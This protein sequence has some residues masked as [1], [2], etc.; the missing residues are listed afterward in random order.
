MFLSSERIHNVRVHGPT[1][2]GILYPPSQHSGARLQSREVP[3]DHHTV[4]NQSN[5][6]VQVWDRC[7]PHTEVTLNIMWTSGIDSPKSAYETLNGHI[8]DL[9]ITP[10]VPVCEEHW[11]SWTH[12]IASHWHRTPLLRLRWDSPQIIT[13]CSV[14]GTNLP[15][16]AS[17][18]TCMYCTQRIAKYRPSPRVTVQ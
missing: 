6:P 17:T 13:D 1:I 10:S 4:H 11:H 15:E 5:V 2:C 12:Q 7:V 14:F 9:N 8:F 18:L 3:H 16:D